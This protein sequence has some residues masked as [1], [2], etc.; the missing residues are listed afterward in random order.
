MLMQ[1][2]IELFPS[3]KVHAEYIQNFQRVL[4]ASWSHEFEE[5][6][7]SRMAIIQFFDKILPIFDLHRELKKRHNRIIK[8][9]IRLG[10]IDKFSVFKFS[11]NCFDLLSI[12]KIKGML[13]QSRLCGFAMMFPCLVSINCTLSLELKL[14]LFGAFCSW[15]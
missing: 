2:R 15:S 8:G 12:I 10:W 13:C 9:A 1:N 7:S 3:T 14:Q 4:N 6:Q 11:D 5:K